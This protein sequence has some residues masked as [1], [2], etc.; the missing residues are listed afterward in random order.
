[1]STEAVD[2]FC[3]ELTRLIDRYRHEWNLTYGECVGALELIKHD[4][5]EEAYHANDPDDPGE[6]DGP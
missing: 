5:L 2:A 4:V 6:P 3:D 1:M